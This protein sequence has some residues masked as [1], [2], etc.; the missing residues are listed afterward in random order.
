MNTNL[1]KKMKYLEPN[2]QNREEG[3][4]GGDDGGGG[5]GGGWGWVM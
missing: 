4:V 2:L 5:G 3:K 1:K